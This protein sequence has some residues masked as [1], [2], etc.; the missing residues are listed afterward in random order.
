MH[1]QQK[2]WGRSHHQH[3]SVRR[4]VTPGEEGTREAQPRFAFPQRTREIRVVPRL[5]QRFGG[6]F[7]HNGEG[8]AL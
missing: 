5:M 8:S 6:A 2:R 7:D 3:P 4:A 1:Q